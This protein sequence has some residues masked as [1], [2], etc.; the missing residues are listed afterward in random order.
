[1]YEGDVK[2]DALGLCGG[3][4]QLP[5]SAFDG[6]YRVRVFLNDATSVQGNFTVTEKQSDDRG[7]ILPDVPFRHFFVSNETI[8][9]T[10]NATWRRM[11][12]V[13]VAR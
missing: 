6:D 3:S 10:F 5:P 7:S 8:K 9:G 2:W 12:C 4:F 11:G 1:M 13:C